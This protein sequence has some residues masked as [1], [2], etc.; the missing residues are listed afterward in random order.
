MAAPHPPVGG[1][2]VGSRQ[3]SGVSVSKPRSLLSHV[4]GPQTLLPPPVGIARWLWPLGQHPYGSRAWDPVPGCARG[5]QQS[6]RQRPRPAPGP[7]LWTWGSPGGVASG[8]ATNRGST[9]FPC[10]PPQ[11]SQG[12]CTHSVGPRKPRA[13]WGHRP[14]TVGTVWRP[15]RP[16]LPSWVF[17]R[18]PAMLG[19]KLGL[20][21]QLPY[22]FL[23]APGAPAGSS[24]AQMPPTRF[25]LKS[26]SLQETSTPPPHRMA[27][28]GRQP[29]PPS[30]RWSSIPHLTLRA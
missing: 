10:C 21:Q 22:S 1:P 20:F 18:N 15:G 8:P 29:Q 7:A 4:D 12:H 17:P 25:R 9:Q 23:R 28:H 26:L 14:Q 13:P 16:V 6:Q 19:V 2:A 24:P 27:R 5:S 3:R 30:R 11:G